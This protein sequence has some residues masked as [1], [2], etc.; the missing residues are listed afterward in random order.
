MLGVSVSEA[1][2]LRLQGEPIVEHRCCSAEEEGA[3]K[4]SD[5]NSADSSSSEAAS[6]PTPTTV[7]ATANA[8]PLLVATTSA[9]AAFIAV[10]P[11]AGQKR[12]A[13]P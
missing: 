4:V 13:S 9:T 11:A 12:K 6:L 3:R 7:A 1:L 8:A 5:A 2:P 10:S